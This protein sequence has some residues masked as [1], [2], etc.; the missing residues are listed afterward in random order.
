MRAVDLFAGAGGTS[1]G[2]RSVGVEIVAA[3][4]H[5]PRAVG[6]PSWGAALGRYHH[7]TVGPRAGCWADTLAAVEARRAGVSL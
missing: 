4:N 3:V 6:A 2:A 5:W 7:G 1:T